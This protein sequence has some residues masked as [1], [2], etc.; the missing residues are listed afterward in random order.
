[1]ITDIEEYFCNGCG[2]C[3]RFATPAC[4]TRQWSRGLSDLRRIC[5]ASGLTETVKWDTRV[6]CMPIAISQSWAPSAATSESA[7]S[8]RP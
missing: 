1:M 4:S 8:M 5:I 6:T 2:R 3:E 7:F